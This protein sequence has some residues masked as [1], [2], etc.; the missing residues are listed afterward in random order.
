MFSISSKDTYVA[1]P[2]LD[3]KDDVTLYLSNPNH[4]IGY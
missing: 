2:F 3:L 4:T 1:Y